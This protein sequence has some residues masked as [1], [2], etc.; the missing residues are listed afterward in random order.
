MWSKRQITLLG[1]VAVLKSLILSKIVHLWLLL[2]NPP[3]VIVKELQKSIF[4]FVWGGKN[5]R[6]SRK[7]S[8]KNIE[9]GG[10]GIPAVRRFMIDLKVTW[11]RKLKI[12]NYKWTH[13]INSAD[14]K[15]I[16]DKLG[17]ATDEGI[18]LNAF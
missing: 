3:D 10:T 8:I 12:S 1:H 18:K 14:K 16:F 17:S 4:Q 6:I 5:D 2:P 9:D 7:V 11:L 15:M 13:I